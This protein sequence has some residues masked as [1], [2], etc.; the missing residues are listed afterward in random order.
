MLSNKNTSNQNSS[1]KMSTK[2]LPGVKKVYKKKEESI[3]Y[4]FSNKIA[5]KSTKSIVTSPYID[6]EI[7]VDKIQDVFSM[8]REK[9]GETEN[10]KEYSIYKHNDLEL[11]VFP[12]GSSFCRQIIVKELKDINIPMGIFVNY[13]EK[14]KISNDYFPCK[15]VYNS[16]IDIVDVIFTLSN[17]I[18]IVLSTI[19]ENNRNFSKVKKVEDLGRPDKIKKSKNAW[20][21][22][23]VDVECSC[24]VENVH[25]TIKMLVEV[26]K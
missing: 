15:Y 18:K 5:V 9:Y 8:L 7:P 17:D 10:I 12:D 11:T 20:C 6:V 19:Y 22:L 13:K 3:E 26:F 4:R 16:S 2:P 25:N 1:K 23:Y 21:E 24:D 14:F